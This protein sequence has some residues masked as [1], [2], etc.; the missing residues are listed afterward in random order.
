MR[1]AAEGIGEAIQSLDADASFI[2]LP[3]LVA[4]SMRSALDA[5]GELTG[6]VTPD[7]VL[8]RVFS[9]FCVGK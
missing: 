7:D 8:G 2:A 9:G 6:E 5:L 3:E 4:S 1:E